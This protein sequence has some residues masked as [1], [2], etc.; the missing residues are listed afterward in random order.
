MVPA[1][2]VTADVITSQIT[3]LL[4][5]SMRHRRPANEVNPEESL[6]WADYI[7]ALLHQ[8]IRRNVLVTEQIKGRRLRD[9]YRDHVER[10]QIMHP[11][12]NEH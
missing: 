8:D 9:R 11:L 4:G 3:D 2:S 6:N 7:D 12:A 5:D 10:T 1:K